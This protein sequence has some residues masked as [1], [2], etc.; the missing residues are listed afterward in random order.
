[1]NVFITFTSKNNMIITLKVDNILQIVCSPHDG[2]KIWVEFGKH[3]EPYELT[4]TEYASVIR[5]LI[6]IEDI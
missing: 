4:S 2:H 1:M 6:N 5:K 3:I